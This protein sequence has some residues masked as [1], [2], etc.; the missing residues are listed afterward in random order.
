MV[1]S[2]LHLPNAPGCCHPARMENWDHLKTVDDMNNNCLL[3]FPCISPDNLQPATA[4]EV[5]DS[6]C[7]LLS[8]L[9]TCKEEQG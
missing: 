8:G 1:L 5:A 6:F 9:Y 4:E 3:I 7:H 2:V